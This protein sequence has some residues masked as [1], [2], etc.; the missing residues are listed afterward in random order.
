MGLPIALVT[1]AVVLS[2]D[3]DVFESN[4]VASVVRLMLPDNV[5]IIELFSPAD[6]VF[7]SAIHV[8]EETSPRIEATVTFSAIL[9]LIGT[10]P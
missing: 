3:N 10:S 5:F 9:G 8:L 2:R 6:V 7:I 4:V 1:A